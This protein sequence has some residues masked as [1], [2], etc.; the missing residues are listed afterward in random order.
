MQE[1]GRE[2]IE[3]SRIGGMRLKTQFLADSRTE[4][5]R[6]VPLTLEGLLRTQ[7][8]ISP[9]IKRGG[10]YLVDAIYEGVDTDPDPSQD[11]YQLFTEERETKIESFAPRDVLIETFGATV[12]AEG[13][14]KFPPTL[15]KPKSRIGQPLTL[16]TYKNGDGAETPNPLHNTTTYGVPHTTAIWRLVRKKVPASL[17]RQARQVIDRLPSGFD[18]QG[19]KAQWYVRPLQKRKIGNAWEVEW[20]AFEISEFSDLTVLATLQSRDRKGRGAGQGLLVT[21]L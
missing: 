7:A 20:Q 9:W 18:Y 21:G 8:R 4:A 3:I 1:I 19:P 5:M 12:D 13:R 10:Q 11:E 14:L 17:E 16:D 15:P 2:E 6:D